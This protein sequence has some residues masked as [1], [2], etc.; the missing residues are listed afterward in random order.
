MLPGIVCK[1]CL[2][3]NRV[4][5]RVQQPPAEARQFGWSIRA[6][7]VVS[8]TLRTPTPN[9][10]E[11]EHFGGAVVVV[12]SGWAELVVGGVE[13][14]PAESRA[15]RGLKAVIVPLCSVRCHYPAGLR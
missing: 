11:T 14:L 2:C 9:G 4:I 8:A 5:G 10:L 1:M 7:I 12:F 15:V 6:F 3:L 13:Q